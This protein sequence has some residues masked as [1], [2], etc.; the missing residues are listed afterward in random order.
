[1]KIKIHKGYGKWEH[2]K[3][4]KKFTILPLRIYQ[5]T[6]QTTW[7]SW[8]ETTYILKKWEIN[9]GIKTYI[10]GG[11]WKKERISDI[12]EYNNYINSKQNNR[13]K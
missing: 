9:D 2:F 12:E 4:I 8:F 1:M 11:Y 6:S 7:W 13:I 10:F 5:Y 3:V